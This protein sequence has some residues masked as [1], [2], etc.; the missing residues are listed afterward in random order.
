MKAVFPIYHEMQYQSRPQECIAALKLM[1][2]DEIVMVT[3]APWD[4]CPEG[5]K[6][7]LAKHD[8]ALRYLHFYNKA[9]WTIRKEKPDLVFLH[10]DFTAPVLRWLIKRH[11]KGKILFDESEL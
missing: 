2:V 7:V 8:D 3:I 6:V 9:I 10:D 5:V 4:L 11:F 1:G